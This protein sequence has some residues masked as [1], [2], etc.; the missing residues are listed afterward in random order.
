MIEVSDLE[1]MAKQWRRA[2][3]RHTFTPLLTD[4]GESAVEVGA[5]SGPIRMS[6][7]NLPTGA[8]A[9]ILFRPAAYDLE[10][11]ITDLAR[12]ETIY[13]DFER[14]I[15]SSLTV[16]LDASAT[17]KVNLK[18][19]ETPN[20]TV[21]AVAGCPAEVVLTGQAI[22]LA[23]GF[24]SDAKITLRNATCTVAGNYEWV[25]LDQEVELQVRRGVRIAHLF[26]ADEARLTTKG[27]RLKIGEF[28]ATTV[29]LINPGQE[30]PV[31]VA[32]DNAKDAT[33]IGEGL[34]HITLENGK[35]LTLAGSILLEVR[36][37]VEDLKGLK[38]ATKVPT[39]RANA[40][41]L[42]LGLSGSF[43][44]DSI[45]GANLEGGRDG[46]I[47]E[48][49][50][51]SSLAS[52]KSAREKVGHAVI[53]GFRVPGGLSG[54]MLLAQ[55][56]DAFHLD[57][58]TQGL[59]GDE[60][61]L[62]I[63]SLPDWRSWILGSAP[64]RSRSGHMHHDAELMRELHRLVIA[65]GAPGAT[66]TRVGWC[67][68][69]LRHA[70]T[71]GFIERLALTGYRWL[72]YGERPGP[73]L[74]TWIVLSIAGAATVLGWSPD[75]S[76]AGVQRLLREAGN[77]ATGPLAAVMRSG[78]SSLSH[79]YEYVIRALVAI[80]LITAALALRNYVKSGSSV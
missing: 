57:P 9:S 6:F 12:D 69:R 48:R 21:K 62:R 74:L 5:T 14:A 78:T 27:N 26:V 7:A 2:N 70:T 33:I 45:S 66:R 3:R 55:M 32:I 18:F 30:N 20:G 58:A 10:V 71:T 72:G 29:T 8:P 38:R 42:A 1:A 76:T 31:A 49:I 54:R 39:L 65:K 46:F 25:H 44:L 28:T 77:Q 61:R 51:T 4:S 56:D 37:L 60:F 47:I 16:N 79:Q 75:L 50:R 22:L 80:P 73:A 15:N 19:P 23:E 63:S 52:D 40:N 68:Y 43:E 34:P 24:S 64:T 59:P 36:G 13:V 53:R 35:N 67:S 11:T 41:A 17:G